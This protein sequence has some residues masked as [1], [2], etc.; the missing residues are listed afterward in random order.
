MLVFKDRTAVIELVY[1]MSKFWF[2]ILG[3]FHFISH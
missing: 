2:D 1:N 3:F